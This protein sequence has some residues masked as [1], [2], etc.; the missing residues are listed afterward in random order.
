VFQHLKFASRMLRKNPMFTLIAVATLAL[1]IGAITAVFT[2][3]DAVL[4]ASGLS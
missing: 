3:V 1:G 2:L 4:L